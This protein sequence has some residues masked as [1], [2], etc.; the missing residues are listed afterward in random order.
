MSRRAVARLRRMSRRRLGV[1]AVTVGGGVGDRIGSATRHRLV[2]ESISMNPA[3]APSLLHPRTHDPSSSP[4]ERSHITIQ[5]PEPLCFG[6]A[7]NLCVTDPAVITAR[8]LGTAG[9]SGTRPRLVCQL[10]T[11][12]NTTFMPAFVQSHRLM[13]S[14][15]VV[16][17]FHGCTDVRG[18]RGFHRCDAEASHMQSSRIVP[19][20]APHASSHDHHDGGSS[21]KGG[22]FCAMRFHRSTAM[23]ASCRGTSN[24]FGR[25]AQLRVARRTRRKACVTAM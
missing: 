18:R 21:G 11:N 23:E 12:L 6:Q 9:H 22:S 3:G 1:D 15:K 7:R 13:S 24:T 19:C 10:I 17:T 8:K 14:D 25:A 5:V 20:I 4:P 2:R 16:N